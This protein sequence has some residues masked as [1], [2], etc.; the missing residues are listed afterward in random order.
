MA[1]LKDLMKEYDYYIKQSGLKL[2]AMQWIAISIFTAIVLAVAAIM[3]NLYVLGI[4]AADISLFKIP[5]LLFIAA[6]DLSLGYPY[7]LTTQK[8][9]KIEESLSDA[10]KQMAD[11]LRAGGTYEFA[12]REISTSGYGPLSSEMNDVL[13][14]L[15]EGQSFENAL[16][17]FGD[18]IKSTLVKRTVTI[19]NQSIR[20]GA[21]L[22]DVLDDV[23]EDMKELYRIGRERQAKTLMQV[24]FIVMAGGLVAPAIFGMVSKIISFLIS[25]AIKAGI[26]TSPQIISEA[27]ATRGL[28]VSL[29]EAYMVIEIVVSA[30]IISL[31]REGNLNKSIIYIP[32]LLFIAFSIYFIAGIFVGMLVNL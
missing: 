15:E 29:M 32:F 22:A 31:M 21:G 23:A 28:I 8:I 7:L 6:I 30:A 14:S 10:L 18:R 27:I 13:R 19:I 11:T 17:G 16:S 4:S 25:S 20:A 12:I 9:S 3:V 24:L 1:G 5:L 26:A 2:N